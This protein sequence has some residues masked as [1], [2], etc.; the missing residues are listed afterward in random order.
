MYFI[1]YSYL[2]IVF[3]LKCWRRRLRS[4][5]SCKLPIDIACLT[6]YRTTACILYRT[7]LTCILRVVYFI[8]ALCR[9]IGQLFIHFTTDD[10]HM[11]TYSFYIPSHL[12]HIYNILTLHTLIIYSL[13][14]YT[15]LYCRLMGKFLNEK[16]YE[17]YE[18]IAATFIGFGLYLFLDSSEG[19]VTVSLG[20]SQLKAYIQ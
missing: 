14:H 5:P 19:T 2:A 6:Y 18:Y 10:I 16:T 15:L 3:L 13:P 12:V 4:Y 9:T 17:S 7:T 8:H 11:Y 20:S 1:C